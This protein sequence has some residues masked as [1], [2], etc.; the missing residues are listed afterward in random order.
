MSSSLI[1][2]IALIIGPVVL[3]G[4]IA[5]G[6]FGFKPERAQ[7]I[8]DVEADEA[9]VIEEV[10]LIQ[11]ST[12]DRFRRGRVDRHPFYLA[13][14]VAAFGY[15]VCILSGAPV[16]SNLASLDP[17]TKFTM[18]A[19]F[20]VGSTLTLVGAA[21]GAEILRW[22]IVGGVRDHLAAA[23]LGDDVRL[24]YT[25]GGIGMFS[26]GV[27]TGIYSTT[28][29]SATFGSLGGW[30]TGSISVACMVMMVAFYRRTRQYSRTLRVV[31][32]EAVANVIQRGGH[33]PQ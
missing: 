31:V 6:V 29:F 17:K 27:S 12:P 25:F 4:C 13:P 11:V 20:L 18:A 5:F 10:R 8:R 33:E 24:P 14:A 2:G 15:S 19:C 23:L 26:M 22:S 30:L 1:I 7:A 28:S 9:V 32:D 16:T 21:M 3:V